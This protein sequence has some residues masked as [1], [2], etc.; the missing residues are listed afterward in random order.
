MLGLNGIAVMEKIHET[1]N[2][3]VYRGVRNQENQPVIIKLLREQ[4]PTTAQLNRYKQE[5][6]IA[7][8]LEGSGFVSAYSLEKYQNSLLIIFEDFGGISLSTLIKKEGLFCGGGRLF[9]EY[10]R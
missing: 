4:Q 9:L 10:C 1:G 5:Y 7:Q 6:E 2:S 8:M 3:I